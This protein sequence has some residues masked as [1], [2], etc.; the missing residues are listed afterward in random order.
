MAKNP[1]AGLAK[2]PK[3]DLLFQKAC[4]HLF[5]G[6]GRTQRGSP[7]RQTRYVAFYN[8]RGTCEQY[9]KEGKGAVRG[10]LPF[11][12]SSANPGREM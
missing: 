12:P 1:T 11:I 9:I 2:S 10:V 4:L 6:D 7:F 8:H 5:L 3:A